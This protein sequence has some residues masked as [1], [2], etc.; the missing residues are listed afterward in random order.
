VAEARKGEHALL[1]ALR[2]AEPVLRNIRLADSVAVTT[3]CRT[4]RAR[5][6]AGQRALGAGDPERARI[7]L[8]S[9]YAQEEIEELTRE[10]VQVQAEE[11]RLERLRRDLDR[12]RQELDARVKAVRGSVSGLQ[13]DTSG[14]LAELADVRDRLKAGEGARRRGNLE[15]A[16]RTFSN[17]QGALDALEGE[18]IPQLRRDGEKL[19]QLSRQLVQRLSELSTGLQEVRGRLAGLSYVEVGRA[20]SRLQAVEH[21]VRAGRE[22]HRNRDYARAGKHADAASRDLTAVQQ[23]VAELEGIDR[24]LGELHA[25][26]KDRRQGYLALQ[27]RLALLEDPHLADEQEL[28]EQALGVL[29]DVKPD[30]RLS[31]ADPLEQLLERTEAPDQV[32]ARV[33]RKLGARPPAGRPVLAEE[34]DGRLVDLS[35]G[36]ETLS[37]RL[38]DAEQQG[39]PAFAERTLLE[40]WRAALERAQVAAEAERWD[41]AWASLAPL[42]RVRLVEAQE[43]L[44]R[45]I[46]LSQSLRLKTTLS[47]AR[48]STT[49]KL[50][51]YNVILNISGAGWGDAGSIKGNIKVAYKDRV[52]LR[53][54]I[55]DLTTVINLVLGGRGGMRGQPPEMKE[56]VAI[57]SLAALG[58]MMY[59]LFLPVPIQEH[60]REAR[61]SILLATDDL[62]LPWELMHTGEEF[63]CLRNPVGR[64]PIMT[65]F[66]RRNTFERGERLRFLFIANPTGDLPASEQEVDRIVA[67]LEGMEATVWKGS[68]VTN[69]KLYQALRSGEYDVIHYS[70]HAFFNRAKPDESGLLLADDSVFIADT[71]QRMLRGRPLVFLNACESGRELAATEEV[72][73]TGSDNEGLA[74][75]FIMGGALGF[76]GTLWPIFDQGASSFAALF[77]EHLL[78]G[79]MLGE[80]MRQARLAVRSARPNDVTWAS[81]ILY[82][83]PTLRMRGEE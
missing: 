66:P 57:D 82:G 48:A 71:I 72:N 62:E 28:V 49:G 14:V 70:G 79:E 26:L 47:L 30:R 64:M 78:N 68:E 51:R 67:R 10:V 60:L 53:H 46:A 74:L 20:E 43:G 21:A 12:Q 11:E 45:R 65:R 9:S 1:A 58:D 52:D 33:A 34:I 25:R 17:V 18:K 37:D 6:E 59:G 73:Y 80:A 16:R 42:D 56:S 29:A 63:L 3:A 55:D 31:S 77:Y 69:L 7:I 4:L 76:I 24:R 50:N 36:L 32:Q 27:A 23:E 19:R 8:G 5:L 75:S 54:A 38:Q 15:A 41:E 44:E 81:F 2:E 22:A 83:D 35:L 61:T 13:V 40:E 39:V